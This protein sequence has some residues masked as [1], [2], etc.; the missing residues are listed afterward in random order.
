M[1]RKFT[2]TSGWGFLKLWEEYFS[3]IIETPNRT[4]YGIIIKNN[5]Q[6]TKK[7]DDMESY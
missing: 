4:Q 1:E 2:L 7:E 3:P 5:N 6:Y